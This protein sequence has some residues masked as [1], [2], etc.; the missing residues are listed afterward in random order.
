MTANSD[1]PLDRPPLK[2]QYWVLALVLA[3]VAVGSVAVLTWRGC[4]WEDPLT[5]AERE[6]EEKKKQAEADK[7]KEID[8][9]VE[10]VVMRPGEPQSA[11]QFVK[12][13]HWTTAS[14]Q[15][16]ALYENFVGETQVGMVS[17]RD[18]QDVAYAID[19]TPFVLRASRPVTLSKGRP[20]DVETTLLVPPVART[21][22]VRTELVERGFGR[23]IPPSLLPVTP[24]PTYQYYFVVLAKEPA[25]YTFVKTID[26]VKVPFDGETELDDADDP[27]H[28]Q[29][30]MLGVDRTVPLSDSPLTWTSIAY[31]LWDEV[32]P[33]LFT[34]EQERALVDW[35]HWGG[36]LVINGPDS[37]DLLGG[38]FLE[39]YL[40]ATGGGSRSIAAGDPALDELNGRWMISTPLLPDRPL[41][42]TRPWSGIH[43]NVQ[44]GGTPVI[45]TGSLL[46]ERPVGRG[47]IVVSAMQLAER[48]LVNWQSGFQSLFNACILRR[49]P[50][51]YREGK[52]G[53]VTLAWADPKLADRRLDARLTTNMAYMA[54]DLGVD[55]SYRFIEVD[56][57]AAWQNQFGNTGEFGPIREYRPPEQIGGIGAWNDFSA[58]ADAAR[59]ALKEAAGVEVPNTSF[60]V[61]WLAAYLI[62]LVP[63][64]WLVFHALGRIE[65]AWIAAPIIAIAGAFVVI[66][67][68]QLDIGFVR[69]QTEIGLL[70]LQP[71]YERGH[72]TRYTSLYTSLSTTYD[73]EFDSLTA[74]AA[75]FPSSRD[76]SRFR[77]MSRSIC[78]FHRYDKSR[79]TGVFVSSNTANLV[80]SEQMFPLEGAIRLGK[81]TVQNRPQIENRSKFHLKS[82][83]VVQRPTR[84]D[85]ARGRTELVGTWIGELRPGESAAVS[86]ASRVPAT[87]EKP[88]FTD[89]RAAEER[90]QHSAR[91]NLEPTFQL[92][93]DAKNIE[94]GEKRLVARIDEVLPGETVEPAA[95]QV[96][97][98]TL[99][100]V[101]LEYAPRP[102]PEPDRNT[103]QSVANL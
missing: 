66:R 37:L 28:Y 72:L 51:E 32:D 3:A 16:K 1:E 22:Q 33:A 31:V 25:R 9:K 86:F 43:L 15:M 23:T 102:D 19:F 67:Q 21:M 26:S 94:P 41:V 62:L 76:E 70:E 91:L 79:L 73:L 4:G 58:T 6:A 96:R 55:T 34:P 40:P 69:A 99:V 103:A 42:P 83:A 100:V 53:G 12:P 81:S 18:G 30:A 8:P 14:Q 77:G 27:V 54:R 7:K 11:R 13:G 95:S 2:V 61:L 29:V 57:S 39:P 35:L 5:A 78:D 46:V 92:A 52:F 93:L 97:G 50:R 68:A 36:Q 88:A 59:A 38:S 49:P 87:K 44:P 75:P 82:V 10:S 47:R 24:M 101:H 65:W 71:D 17:R 74:V 84:E 90:L 64:N 45:S 63:L 98:A 80:H 60:V 89:E 56:D 85:E 48:D 20:K